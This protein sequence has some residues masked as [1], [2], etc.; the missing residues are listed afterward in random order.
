MQAPDAIELAEQIAYGDGNGISQAAMN[1][2]RAG[3]VRYLRGEASLEVAL[4]LTGVARKA[5]R[6]RAL[7]RAA[8]ILDNGRNLSAW[9]L[10]K[11]L[12]AAIRRFDKVIRPR[13]NRGA[14]VE[15]SPV[16]AAIEAAYRSGACMTR[17]GRQLL[18]LL[19]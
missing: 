8:S 12:D 3:L 2:L 7:I 1:W 18:R 19:Q 11:L 9:E 4:Q 15:L 17:S 10:S 14:E 13:L 6:N 16:D 5:N